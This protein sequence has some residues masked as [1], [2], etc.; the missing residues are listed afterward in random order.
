M[1]TIMMPTTVRAIGQ[2]I[3]LTKLKM[4]H[5]LHGIFPENQKRLNIPKIRIRSP[6]AIIMILMRLLGKAILII[7]PFEGIIEGLRGTIIEAMIYSK[8][9]IPLAK[10]SNTKIRRTKVGSILKYSP[11]PPQTPISIR[12]VRDR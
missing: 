4:N 1:I 2:N 12:F 10:T 5:G 11:M 6:T 3:W 7:G 9:P 8:M